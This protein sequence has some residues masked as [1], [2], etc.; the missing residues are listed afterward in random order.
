MEVRYD[1]VRLWHYEIVDGP[2]DRKSNEGTRPPTCLQ[3]SYKPP[4]AW[5]QAQQDHHVNNEPGFYSLENT[6][7]NQ[8]VSSCKRYWIGE[9]GY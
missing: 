2:M 4:G 3:S 8:L 5:C 1:S 6:K 7:R 9:L